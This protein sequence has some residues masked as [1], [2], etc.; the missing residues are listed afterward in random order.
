MQKT[1]FRILKAPVSQS[2]NAIV[3]SGFPSRACETEDGSGERKASIT[4][5]FFLF[6]NLKP[7]QTSREERARY[8]S[9]FYCATQRNVCS[10][11]ITQLKVH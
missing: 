8:E 1:R 3:E 10:K 4:P 5:P 9:P 7:K 2:E 11:G 6:P